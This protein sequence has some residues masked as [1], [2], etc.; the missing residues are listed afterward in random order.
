MHDRLCVLRLKISAFSIRRL[1][2][3]YL[4]SEKL[5][6]FDALCKTKNPSPN[7]AANLSVELMNVNSELWL[8]EDSIRNTGEDT[9][10]HLALL[11]KRIARYNDERNRLIREIDK[12]YGCENPVEEKIYSCTAQK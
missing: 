3:S 12:A 9:V 1:D 4:E 6:I 5:A 10:E 11:A 8:M 2:K 7:G